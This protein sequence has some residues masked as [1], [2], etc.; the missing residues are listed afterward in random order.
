MTC[1]C[2]AYES[3]LANGTSQELDRL[4]STGLDYLSDC[5]GP[6]CLDLLSPL[7]KR[8]A[9]CSHLRPMR[10]KEPAMRL[11]WISGR[12]AIRNACEL[13]DLAR[14]QCPLGVGERTMAADE[15]VQR[16]PN[17]LP[18]NV[19]AGRLFVVRYRRQRVER[20][21]ALRWREIGQALE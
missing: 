9:L 3:R 4:D 1:R 16:R 19:L 12:H 15:F 2:G 13:V 17:R 10:V 8:V 18:R 21:R 14:R 7:G 5:L 20:A 11:H 6:C